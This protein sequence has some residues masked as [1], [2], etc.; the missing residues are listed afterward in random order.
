[1][2]IAALALLLAGCTTT[3]DHLTSS[4]PFKVVHSQQA[5]AAVAD[6]LL[7]RLSSQEVVPTRESDGSSTTLSFN[8]LGLARRPAIYVFVIRDEQSGSLIDVHRFA[9]ATL[10]AAE[11]CF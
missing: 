7:N 2:R 10:A 5:R 1:M 8:G 9:G 6:C 3:T 4:P 11:T